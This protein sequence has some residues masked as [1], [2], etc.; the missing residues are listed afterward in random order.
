[1][2]ISRSFAMIRNILHYLEPSSSLM[3]ATTTV[4]PSAANLC[5]QAVPIPEDH[6]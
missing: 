3:S 1:M 5:A 4:A 6:P 2:H